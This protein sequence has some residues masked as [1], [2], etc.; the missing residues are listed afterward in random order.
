MRRV[1]RN[2]ADQDHKD[3]DNEPTS[4]RLGLPLPFLNFRL[5]N[6]LIYAEQGLSIKERK[7]KRNYACSETLPTSIREEGPFK[8]KAMYKSSTGKI[9]TK[10]VNGDQVLAVPHS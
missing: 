4:S 7:E 9:E 1:W 6:V 2:I 5:I 3:C 10:E 8:A